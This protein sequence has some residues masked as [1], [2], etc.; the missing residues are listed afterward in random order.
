MHW[1]HWQT[2]TSPVLHPHPAEL[3]L[4]LTHPQPPSSLEAQSQLSPHLHAACTASLLLTGAHLQSV[5]EQLSPHEHLC[6]FKVASA[7]HWH[8]PGGQV[9]AFPERHPQSNSTSERFTNRMINRP[10]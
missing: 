6:E 3:F 9:Q 4:E 10:L 8:S 1:T 7:A 5:Q 2:A